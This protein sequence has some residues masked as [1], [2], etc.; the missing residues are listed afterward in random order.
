MCHKQLLIIAEFLGICA[1]K[2]ALR[3]FNKSGFA[4]QMKKSPMYI[5]CGYVRLQHVFG[6]IEKYYIISKVLIVQLLSP[7]KCTALFSKGIKQVLY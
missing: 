1:F 6:N 2:G 5:V 4:T 3:P 7:L